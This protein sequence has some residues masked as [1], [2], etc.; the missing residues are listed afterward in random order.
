MEEFSTGHNPELT[1]GGLV[2]SQGGWSQ[3]LA[4]QRSGQKHESDERILGAG[5]FVQAV[6]LEV[7]ERQLRQTKL[8]KRGKGIA[9]IL[10]EECKKRGVNEQELMRGSR[11]RKVSH[12]RSAIALRCKEEIGCSGAEIARYLGVNTTSI[13]RSVERA[14]RMSPG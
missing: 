4:L 8:R 5:D 3:V 9:D 11:R 7:E 14:E 2:R 1:G 10:R 13:N 12:A 6:M